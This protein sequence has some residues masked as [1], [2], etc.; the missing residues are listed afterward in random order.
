[1][2]SFSLHWLVADLTC[3]IEGRPELTPPATPA[4]RQHIMMLLLRPVRRLRR[5]AVA[6]RA[7][8]CS[9]AAMLGDGPG[10]LGMS[11]AVAAK[12]PKPPTPAAELEKAD[13]LRENLMLVPA[14]IGGGILGWLIGKQYNNYCRDK[15]LTFEEQK[16]LAD[17][18]DAKM[19]FTVGM[20]YHLGQGTERDNEAAYTYFAKGSAQ[21][22]PQSLYC[23]G[24]YTMAG[25][26]VEKDDAKAVEFFRRSAEGGLPN[27]Q[28]QLAKCYMEG[29]GVEA[30]QA[31][32]AK[33]LEA[34]SNKGSQEGKYRLAEIKLHG[35]GIEKDEAAAI[36]LLEELA[37]NNHGEAMHR[38]GEAYFIG[39][40]GL[41]EDKVKAVAMWGKAAEAGCTPALYVLGVCYLRAEGVERD[42]ETAKKYFEGAAAMGDNNAK[43]Q[44]AMLASEEQA[45]AQTAPAAAS[46]SSESERTG[47]PTD[48]DAKDP[49]FV[50][51]ASFGGHKPGFKY[52]TGTNGV[53]YYRD[54]LSSSRSDEME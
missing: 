4:A 46:G 1:M 9:R 52:G 47:I 54:E 25:T 53:G 16:K 12:L 7:H 26:T 6:P 49:E 31:E 21:D 38:L 19:Q 50:P 34:A 23:S 33:W 44:L 29:T 2:H 14:V 8:F 48:A 45:Q 18:G 5:I 30:D 24:I 27:A 20:A 3:I 51:A 22:E 13:R 42:L 39:A 37:Q 32:G 35:V 15:E 36:S 43:M 41:T 17:D 40:G 10:V 28:L 11:R